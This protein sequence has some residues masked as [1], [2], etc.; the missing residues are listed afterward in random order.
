MTLNQWLLKQVPNSRRCEDGEI[1]LKKLRVKALRKML[2]ERGVKCLGCTEKIHFIERVKET[3]H[4]KK[5]EHKSSG[6][7]LMQER[8]MKE[9]K[10]LVANGWKDQGVGDDKHVVHL[11]DYN[12]KQYLEDHPEGFLVMFYAPWCGHCKEAKPWAVDA[13]RNVAKWGAS[14]TIVAVDAE[15]NP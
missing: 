13:A 1:D 4:M 5:K 12:F 15:M 8:R 10:E 3:M 6:M 7:T 11:A 14:Q 9:Q 2:R